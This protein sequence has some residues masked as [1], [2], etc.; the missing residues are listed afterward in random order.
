M[1]RLYSEVYSV[2][3]VYIYI[4]WNGIQWWIK[5]NSYTV[6]RGTFIK[7]KIL[8]IIYVNGMSVSC[9]IGTDLFLL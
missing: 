3:Y 9:N 6:L 4:T 7:V 2:T 8:I 1:K 5:K